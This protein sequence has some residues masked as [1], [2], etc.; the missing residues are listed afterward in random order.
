MVTKVPGDVTP[1]S[2]RDEDSPGK[3]AC[4]P[5]GQGEPRQA[6]GAEETRVSRKPDSGV[7]WEPR[8]LG[9]Q[10]CILSVF[11][12]ERLERSEELRAL[13]KNRSARSVSIQCRER[14]EG[15]R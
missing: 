10:V 13:A 3:R 11:R 12:W 8:H 15:T 2:L 14:R 7:H 9:G 5:A 1:K 4:R 6:G